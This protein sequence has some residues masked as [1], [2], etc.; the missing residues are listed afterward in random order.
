MKNIVLSFDG[1]HATNAAALSRLLDQNAEQVTWYSPGAQTSPASRPSLRWRE[2]ATEQARTSIAQAYTFL[3]DWWAPGD[4]I[5]LFGAGRGAS[6]ARALARLVGTVGLLPDRSDSL[7]DWVL[8][9]YAL[10]RTERSAQDWR[11]VTQLAARLSG[12]RE[13]RVPVRFL[14]LWD[15]AKLPGLPTV[16]QSEPLEGVVAGRHALAIDAGHGPF[17]QHP[18]HA[19]SAQIEEV[20]F[21]GAHCDVAGGRDAC[22]P[23]ADIALDWVLDGALAA[24]IRLRPTSRCWAPA[25]GELDA[26]AGSARAVSSRRLPADA[27]IHASVE[28]YLRAHP[29]YWR[30]LPARLGWADRD[31]A[32]RGERL[33]AAEATTAVEPRVLAPAS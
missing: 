12:Q 10:P 14:G 13:I 23:L 8:A 29:Q 1:T 11:R 18:V 24:G 17:G 22:W 30:R 2:A 3:V 6:C 20:W 7:F 31:W 28:V 9:N 33:V 4:R 32:A 5:Y 16:P 19:G 27:Q 15:A 21:R 26:L 25:P